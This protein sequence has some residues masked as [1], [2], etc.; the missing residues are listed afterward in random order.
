M[1]FLKVI[2]FIVVIILSLLVF[3]P[4]QSLYFLAEHELKKYDVVISDEKFIPN[5]FG[6]K[7]EDAELHVKGVNIAKLNSV[8]ISLSG[9]SVF[10]KDIGRANAYISI[11]NQ[12]VV[13]DFEPTKTFIKK[14]KV[15]LKYFKKLER[16]K[17][18]YEYKL[19]QSY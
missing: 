8:D 10:S 17:Y 11:D 16:G 5:L 19:N 14:Y 12:S 1:K 4:K 18:K 13:I 3:L 6:F 7:L 9:A 2:S 15:A